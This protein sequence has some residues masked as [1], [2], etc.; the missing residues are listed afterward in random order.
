MAVAIDTWTDTIHQL[1]GLS[2]REDLLNPLCCTYMDL[3]ASSFFLVHYFFPAFIMLWSLINLNWD[4]FY[5]EATS[6]EMYGAYSLVS[7][8]EEKVEAENEVRDGR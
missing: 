1:L 3:T 4:S 5:M 2:W 6:S 7:A 8:G